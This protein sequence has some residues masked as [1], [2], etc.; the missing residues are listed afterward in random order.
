MRSGDIVHVEFPSADADRAQRFWSGLFG[1]SFEDS[2]TA[3]MDY[4]IARTSEQMG[5]A[6]FPSEKP[7]GYP[8]YY[9]A[10]DDIEATIAKVRELGGEGEEKMPVP[11]MGWFAICKDSEGNAFHLFQADSSAA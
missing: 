6:V 5:A 2:G 3:D 11:A 1:W 10:T 7:T 4:R 9:F 8:N